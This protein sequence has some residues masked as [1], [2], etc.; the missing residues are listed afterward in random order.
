MGPIKL[1]WFPIKRSTPTLWRVQ[2]NCITLAA[3]YQKAMSCIQM[4]MMAEDSGRRRTWMERHWTKHVFKLA[5][6]ILKYQWAI[7][8]CERTISGGFLSLFHTKGRQWMERLKK[9]FICNFLHTLESRWFISDDFTRAPFS[10]RTKWKSCEEVFHTPNFF[11]YVWQSFSNYQ[12]KKILCAYTLLIAFFIHAEQFL[13]R[14]W[15]DHRSTFSQSEY[16]IYFIKPFYRVIV[17]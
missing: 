12:P 10:W 6:D 13:R 17:S 11:P 3:M 16:S 4:Q 15:N 1:T 7:P 8:H 9:K 2:V 14:E 5:R